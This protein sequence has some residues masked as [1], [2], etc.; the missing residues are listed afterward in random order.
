MLWFNLALTTP[1]EDMVTGMEPHFPDSYTSGHTCTEDKAHTN[2]K[3]TRPKSSV[4]QQPQRG[5]SRVV[6]TAPWPALPSYAPCSS[7]ELGV[8]RADWAAVPKDP[9]NN[10]KKYLIRVFENALKHLLGIDK[11]NSQELLTGN[12]PCAKWI[13]RNLR[14][15]GCPKNTCSPNSVIFSPR[16]SQPSK[17]T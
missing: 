8:H 14:S 6:G 7:E 3:R 9:G 12:Q 10:C 5:V 15:N 1:V 16:Q 11:V 17:S 13:L 2:K 4:H